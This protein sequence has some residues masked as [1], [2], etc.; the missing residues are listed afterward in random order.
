MAHKPYI[1][2]F[3]QVDFQKSTIPRRLYGLPLMLI[4]TRHSSLSG[5]ETEIPDQG[6][7]ARLYASLLILAGLDYL[8]VVVPGNG[9]PFPQGLSHHSKI[10]LIPNHHRI[11][12]FH[13]CGNFMVLQEEVNPLKIRL[14][15]SGGAGGAA[16]RTQYRQQ[17]NNP[18]DRMF[19]D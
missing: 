11:K 4:G 8:P 7:Y 2:F 18:R 9:V 14:C 10:V 5:Y 13:G 6:L 1:A 16:N 17:E 3:V 15:F 12:K 19:H